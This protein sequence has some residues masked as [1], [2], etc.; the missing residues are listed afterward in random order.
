VSVA[1]DA[2]AAG[3]A[4]SLPY[5]TLFVPIWRIRLTISPALSSHMLGMAM[6]QTSKYTFFMRGSFR[7]IA[8]MNTDRAW[9]I[10]GSS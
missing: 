6:P 1:I 4:A 9:S 2:I 8:S 10:V 7:S 3:V 5:R